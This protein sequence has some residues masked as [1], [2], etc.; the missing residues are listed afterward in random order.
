L[1]SNVNYAPLC[2]K[3]GIQKLQQQIT[4]G[5]RLQVFE[6]PI[7]GAYCRVRRFLLRKPIVSFP[8][9]C[10]FDP[11]LYG[12][13]EVANLGL[14]EK[15]KQLSGARNGTSLSQEQCVNILL[16]EAK[17]VVAETILFEYDV[18]DFVVECLTNL[19]VH[20]R[21]YLQNIDLRFLVFQPKFHSFNPPVGVL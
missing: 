7:R 1:Q 14:G 2:V 8:N 19:L 13:L 17:P 11:H 4:V 18:K 20:F 9:N 3:Q 12:Q 5:G 21:N 15:Q 16:Y 10:F 6:T